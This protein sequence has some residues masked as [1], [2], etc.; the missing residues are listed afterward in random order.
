[1]HHSMLERLKNSHFTSV[2]DEFAGLEVSPLALIATIVVSTVL[3]MSALAV[4]A[5]MVVV[6][7]AVVAPWAPVL[8][9]KLRSDWKTYSWLAFF[10]FVVIFQIAHFSE[11]VSQMIELH[12][13]SWAPVL[14]RGI[15]SQLDVE[16][17]HFWWNLSILFSATLLLLRH[18]RNCWLWASLLFSI[19]HQVEHTY[20]Y[21][22]WFLPKGISNHP[23]ILGA[24]GLVD[25]AGIMIPYLTTMGRADLHFWYN[26]FEIGL[27]VVAFVWQASH[28]IRPR[29]RVQLATGWNRRRAFAL[30]AAGQIAIVTLIGLVHYSPATLNVPQSYATIQSAI[31]AA[32][33]LAIIRLAPGVYH[34]ALQIN[35]PLTLAGSGRGTTII[36]LDDD[37]TPTLTVHKTHDVIIKNLTVEGGLYGILVDSSRAIQITSSAVLNSSFVGIR[38]SSSTVDV[39]YSEIAHVRSPYG[40]GI[41]LANTAFSGDSMLRNNTV[42]D[43]PHAGIDLHNSNAMIERNTA[44]HNGLCGIAI[45]EMSMAMVNSNRLTGNRECGIQVADYSTAE[46]GNNQVLDTRPGPSGNAVG[47]KAEYNAE[48]MLRSNTIDAPPGHDVVLQS[49]ASIEPWP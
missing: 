36:Q 13:L 42:H 30:V 48:I 19:W 2:L 7:A 28:V 26:L 18:K 4:S 37:N 6:A 45:Y 20:I 39:E 10:E 34:E 12:F 29:L 3:G 46:L 21:F 41:E 44:D 9:V 49:D 35:K 38:V 33:D 43:I 40:M 8:L 22:W 25:E 23:G 16:P 15:I 14:A 1:M 47:I 32:P 24:G 11:H 31:N 27:F 5:R 17:V